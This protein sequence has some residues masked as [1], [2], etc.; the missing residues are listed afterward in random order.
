MLGLVLAT[1]ETAR[2]V[3]HWL[4]VP[5]ELESLWDATELQTSLSILW[6]V[7]GLSGMVA[8]VRMARRAVWVAGASWMAVVVVKLFLVDLSSLTA[9]GRVVSFIVVGVLLLI[10]GYLAPVPPAGAAEDSEE[11]AG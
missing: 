3:S 11:S 10:V 4:D 2:A 5:W 1:V 8:G 7:I 9:L 6:A